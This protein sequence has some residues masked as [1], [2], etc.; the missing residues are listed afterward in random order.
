[1]IVN[2]NWVWPIEWVVRYPIVY[3]LNVPP[4]LLGSKDTLYWRD[5]LGGLKDFSVGVVWE[6]IRPRR[7]LVT[8]T[9]V[10]WFPH[11]IPRH[12][13]HL[14]LVLKRNRKTQDLLRQWDVGDANLNLFQCLLCDI[15]PRPFIF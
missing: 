7:A 1:M 14:W 11:C 10:V 12:A 9:N 5:N 4:I 13:F 8:W 6:D 15:E 3:N 2:G